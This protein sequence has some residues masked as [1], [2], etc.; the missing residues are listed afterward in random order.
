M[1]R[2]DYS[3]G[4]GS[5][6]AGSSSNQA[7]DVF[8]NTYQ[9][10]DYYR[11]PYGSPS[12]QGAL[13]GLSARSDGNDDAVQLG[14]RVNYDSAAFDMQSMMKETDPEIETRLGEQMWTPNGIK[15]T[16]KMTLDL[17]T[18]KTVSKAALAQRERDREKV[19]DPKTGEVIS[20]AALAQRQ[21]DTDPKTGEV[22]SKAAL[23]IGRAHV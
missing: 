9:N 3:Y 2:V 1:K 19:T 7:S 17:E 14:M 13:S 18:G 12:Y 20:K 15:E 4:S 8:G 16:K 5:A 21:E 23:E 22:I 10:K 11:T 6:N